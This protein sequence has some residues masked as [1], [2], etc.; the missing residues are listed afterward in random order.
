MEVNILI[1]DTVNKYTF[2]FLI[3]NNFFIVGQIRLTSQTAV[4]TLQ[5]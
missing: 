2:F 3:S 4:L 5:H 1:R